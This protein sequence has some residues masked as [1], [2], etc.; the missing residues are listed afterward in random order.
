MT[1]EGQS[2]IPPCPPPRLEGEFDCSAARHALVQYLTQSTKDPGTIGAPPEC[3]PSFV[4]KCL[5]WLPV[6]KPV[7]KP[8]LAMSICSHGFPCALR[9]SSCAS[10]RSPCTLHALP[11]GLR[12]FPVYFRAVSMNFPNARL[13]LAPGHSPSRACPEPGQ[14]PTDARP[15]PGRPGRG[16]GPPWARSVPSSALLV[17]Y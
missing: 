3:V 10:D 16:Q 12:A 4:C 8:E 6:H 15:A 17:R 5:G 7:P 11:C 9:A 14:R 2:I 13:G 1:E